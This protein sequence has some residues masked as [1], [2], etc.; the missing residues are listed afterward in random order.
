M[1]IAEDMVREQL[2][3]LPQLAFGIESSASIIQ[4]HLVL[5]IQASIFRS[6]EGIKGL[7]GIKGRIL[8]PERSQCF[9]SG[10]KQC[11]V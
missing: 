2:H 5:G 6:A 7:R 3:M 9:F 4:V 11:C 1:G 10:C 8:L